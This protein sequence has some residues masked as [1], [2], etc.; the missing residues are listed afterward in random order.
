M[1]KFP[2]PYYDAVCFKIYYFTR[3]R[4][5]ALQSNNFAFVLCI[6]QGSVK[7]P[8]NIVIKPS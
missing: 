5:T 8:S 6:P 4:R 2:K 3:N 1:I 7:S